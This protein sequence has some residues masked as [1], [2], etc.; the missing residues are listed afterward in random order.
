[1]CLHSQAHVYGVYLRH[2]IADTYSRIMSVVNTFA[3]I[4]RSNA[5]A[6]RIHYTG[7]KALRNSVHAR[8]NKSPQVQVY[9]MSFHTF[10]ILI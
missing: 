7:I 1:M 10:H 9:R 2:H 4:L 5:R 6:M 8:I 3:T